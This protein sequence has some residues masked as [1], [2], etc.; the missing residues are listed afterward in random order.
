MRGA[1]SNLFISASVPSA[2]T[3]TAWEEAYLRFKTPVEGVRKFQKRLARL[4]AQTWPRE[5]RVVDL[6]CGSG[7]GMR[8][9]HNLGFDR[10]EGIDISPRL[11]NRYRGP[12][13]L[14]IADCRELPLP[15]ASRDALIVQ[16]G[17][18]H[19]PRLPED[20]EQ[21]LLEVSRVLRPGGRFVMVEPCRT[22]Y[23]SFVH[24]FSKLRVARALSNKVDAFAEMTEN[25]HA[26]YFE[27]L[28]NRD[29]VLTL[30][31]K[32]FQPEHQSVRWGK[33]SFVGKRDE[34]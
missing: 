7:N 4:G 8:A 2:A 30:L 33:M 9:L 3:P 21:T 29:I 26:T 31:R 32:F 15:N 5:S 13:T 27:W 10:I 1:A 19:L 23:L 12:G 20:V 16:G 25:E 11:A 28:K 22:P 14:I 18:H 24:F 6:F 34:K 17:L